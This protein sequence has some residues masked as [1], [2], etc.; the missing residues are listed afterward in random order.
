MYALSCTQP[1]I[2]SLALKQNLLSVCLQRFWVANSTYFLV[3]I[4]I[5]WNVVDS[6]SVQS[7]RCFLYLWPCSHHLNMT[8]MSC[9]VYLVSFWLKPNKEGIIR[10][11]THF[12][13]LFMKRAL[14]IWGKYNIVLL[15]QYIRG[16]MILVHQVVLFFLLF[17]M[18]DS[19]IYHFWVV[20]LTQCMDASFSKIWLDIPKWKAWLAKDSEREKKARC[21]LGVKLFDIWGRQQF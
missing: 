13:F 2:P 4:I 12:L 19:R 18:F 7:K 1:S 20:V 3:F 10:F 15:I 8:T 16:N 5:L 17:W 11:P 14:K 9:V 21:K 6:Y